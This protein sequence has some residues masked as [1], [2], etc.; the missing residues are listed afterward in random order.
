MRYFYLAAVVLL[1]SCTGKKY[2]NP[3]VAIQ[4][5]FGDI[6]VELFPENAPKSVAAFL[7]YVDSGY[8]KDASFYRALN[9]DNQPTGN[10]ST[11]LLQGGIW[12]T[13]P[14]MNISGI[15]HETTLQTKL[16]HKNG[17]ISLARQAP[18]TAG[19]E[20]FIC[21]GDQKG[22]D[23]GGSNNPDGQGY[24]AFGQVVKG[25]SLVQKFYAQPTNDD[26]LQQPVA[27]LNIVRL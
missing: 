12:K 7:S 24:A 26:M 1:L 14:T 16:T 27:I 19:S 13:K 8:Y 3:H 9:D 17:T 2:K 25:M 20:F 10:A 21:I 15:P 5:K 18:G 4:T 23:Y 22:F 6:E 11:A